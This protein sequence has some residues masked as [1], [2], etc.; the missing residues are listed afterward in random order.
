MLF[1]PGVCNSDDIKAV[2]SAVA[3]KP[4]NILMSSNT[5][6]SVK[7]L[8]DMGVRRISVGS[9]LARAAWAGFMRAARPLAEK[10]SFAGMDQLTSFAELNTL[11]GG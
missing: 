4:V 10:G 2:I 3:P 6:L 5:G 1:V 7:D 8:A 11:F 9:A